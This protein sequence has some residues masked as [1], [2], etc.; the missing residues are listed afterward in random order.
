[1]EQL[2]RGL[3]GGKDTGIYRL[4]IYIHP[5]SYIIRVYIYI[6]KYTHIY[7]YDLRYYFLLKDNSMY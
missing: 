5:V 1:M 6:Y 4:Y 3:A 2:L 7:I